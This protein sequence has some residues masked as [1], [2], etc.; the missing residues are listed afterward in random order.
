MIYIKTNKEI[1]EFIENSKVD[2]IP[3][4][5]VESADELKSYTEHVDYTIVRIGSVDDNIE[6]DNLFNEL[7]QLMV[8]YCEGETD[9]EI[10]SLKMELE[11]H[12]KQYKH[13]IKQ[14]NDINND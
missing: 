9:K 7:K 2:N 5:T 8:E 11:H 10:V 12:I 14:Q 3:I 6:T 13:Y 4:R 1:G